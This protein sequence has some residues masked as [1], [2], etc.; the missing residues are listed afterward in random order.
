MVLAVLLFSR[1]VS[2]VAMPA[3]A[4][5]MIVAGVQSIKS[6]RIQ[7]IWVTGWAPRVVMEQRPWKR[8]CLL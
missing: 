1:A 2:L 6:E 5:M 4:G 3:M 7:D 8:G